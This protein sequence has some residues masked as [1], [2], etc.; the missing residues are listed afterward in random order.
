M[1]LCAAPGFTKYHSDPENVE[2]ILEIFLL[3]QQHEFPYFNS[4]NLYRFL[5]FNFREIVSQEKWC[6]VSHAWLK[7]VL[8]RRSLHV[9]DE[10]DIIFAIK[11][12]I[13]GRHPKAKKGAKQKCTVCTDDC[14]MKKQ[15]WDL[16]DRYVCTPGRSS[17]RI[18]LIKFQVFSSK[19]V[20]KA[21][22]Y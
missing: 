9:E 8:N 11:R 22:F 3:R 19:N 20:R 10:R 17:L 2:E 18:Y 15:L 6:Q 13:E 14:T 21:H 5:D 12:W 4:S 1:I 7:H 16:I